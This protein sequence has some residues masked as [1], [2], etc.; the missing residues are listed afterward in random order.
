MRKRSILKNHSSKKVKLTK[1]NFK[2]I[3][4]GAAAP[5][6]TKPTQKSNTGISSRRRTRSRSMSRSSSPRRSKRAN[7]SKRRPLEVTD[8]DYLKSR[9]YMR[10]EPVG[11]ASSAPGRVHLPEPEAESVPG[12]YILNMDLLEGYK[13][14]YDERNEIPF[15][16]NENIIRT[17]EHTRIIWDNLEMICKTDSMKRAIQYIKKDYRSLQVH[18]DQLY[19]LIYLIDNKKETAKAFIIVKKI[20][21]KECKRKDVVSLEA[22]CSSKG[23]RHAAKKLLGFLIYNAIISKFKLILKV[24]QGIIGNIGAYCLYSNLGFRIDSEVFNCYGLPKLDATPKTL[25][26][27][28]R[29]EITEENLFRN[30]RIPICSDRTKQTPK[31]KAKEQLIFISNILRN[32]DGNTKKGVPKIL[33]KFPFELQL[34]IL[35]Y[36][37][38]LYNLSSSSSREKIKE[39]NETFNLFSGQLKIDDFWRNVISKLREKPM[40]FK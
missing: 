26:M 13:R 1:K 27:M 39:F 14:I 3:T 22:I 31:N 34:E 28:L 7:N 32:Y 9:E 38:N 8:T 25:W 23:T 36:L 17:S 20:N 19:D 16:E 18:A 12:S 5:P 33:K 10:K 2:S 11:R 15:D 29:E 30:T 24:D 21:H 6:K 4:G 37:Y 40:S 35:I